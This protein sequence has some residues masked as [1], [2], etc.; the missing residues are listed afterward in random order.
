MDETT[1]TFQN[2]TFRNLHLKLYTVSGEL[3][4]DRECCSDVIQSGHEY[5]ESADVSDVG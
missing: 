3:R 4:S 2:L 5:F 1:I